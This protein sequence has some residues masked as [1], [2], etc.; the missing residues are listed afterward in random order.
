MKFLAIF[1]LAT[2]AFAASPT[3]DIKVDQVGYL[4]SAAK[5]ALVASASPAT[6]FSVRR[7]S[8]DSVM[9]RG[10]LSAAVD[11]P[12]SG[13]RVQTADFSTLQT[14]GKYYLDVANIGRSWNFQ[15][16][17]DVYSRTFY[18]AMRSYYGQ[19]CGT[20]V[21]LGPEFP[22]YKHGAC[23][24]GGQ[25]HPTSGKT[26][27]HPNDGKGW[28]DAGDYGR[29]VVNSGIT[30][31]TLLWTYE[32]FGPRVRNKRLNLPESGNGT[33]DILNEIRWN[34]DWMLSMQDKDGG[35]WHKETSERFCGFIMPEDDK[36]TPYVIGTGA[37]PYK[38]SCAASDFAA[39]MAIAARVYRPFDA[40]FATAAL[41]A[42]QRAWAWVGKNPNVVFH[43]PKGIT[44]GD[45][46]DSN[47]D[48]EHLW[49]AAELWRT[50][51]EAVYEQYLTANGGKYLESIG[52]ANPPNWGN[53]AALGLWSYALGGASTPLAG[54]V[55]AKSLASAG[56][57]VERARTAPYHSDMT[58]KDYNWGSNSNAA[59]YGLQLLVANAIHADPQYVEAAADNLHYIL[60]RNTLS[61]SLVTRVG[62]HPFQHPHHRPSAADG[63]AEPWPGLMSG[64]PNHAKQD[65]E[66]RNMPDLPP[67]KMYLDKTASYASNE[68][69]INW[70][71]PLVF[72]LAGLLPAQ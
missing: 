27:P 3:T 71:S 23:H 20:A 30:T 69:A 51:H 15:I 47:C 39:V 28:H 56:A 18:L 38:S 35:V 26:G 57:L 67:A 22:G 17:S 55:R 5:F 29:Y 14:P 44:T 63:L 62:E 2:G 11:E 50:T 7:S 19:R 54:E 48:D 36:L 58:T 72:L 32:L 10:K 21:D 64:G 52:P 24:L 60:G 43:N 16:A 66:M 1:A 49:A 34:L 25:Y 68:V 40:V 8:D 4:P 61:L 12:D 37:E 59:N 65:P 9:L 33:P 42:A 31:G 6:E 45:Y 46:G 70:N 41:A 13:D 53:V